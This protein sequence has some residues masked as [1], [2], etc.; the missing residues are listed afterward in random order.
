MIKLA[1][2]RDF[3]EK[4]IDIRLLIG[5]ELWYNFLKLYCGMTQAA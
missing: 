3:R 2:T 4:K 5:E 1:I